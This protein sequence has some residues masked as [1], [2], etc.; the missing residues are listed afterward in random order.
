MNPLVFII[1]DIQNKNAN[2]TA[3]R[4]LP[5]PSQRKRVLPI[6]LITTYII[7]RSSHNRS[8][9]LDVER[10]R[11]KPLRP[12]FWRWRQPRGPGGS[13]YDGTAVGLRLNYTAGFSERY[14]NRWAEVG[15]Q[16]MRTNNQRWFRRAREW[17][18]SNSS[19][20]SLNCSV[21]LSACWLACVMLTISRQRGFWRAISGG[22]RANGATVASH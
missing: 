2:I 15:I 14:T 5:S 17:R 10:W 16:R 11:E 12:W 18:S 8:H 20:L 1:S 9:K 22:N 13:H 6:S 3:H 21:W 7:N 4:P 19:K